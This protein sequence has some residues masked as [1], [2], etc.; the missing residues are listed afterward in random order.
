MAKKAQ[1]G[2]VSKK[3]SMYDSIK[4][5]A[6]NRLIAYGYHG[7]TFGAIAESLHITT[8]NI[9][10]HFGSK[11][12]L[13]E[14][15]VKDYVTN[16]SFQHRAIWLDESTSLAEKVQNVVK[17]NY[18]LYKKFNR[19]KQAKNPWSLIGRMRLESDVLSDETNASLTSF[20]QSINE[21]IVQAVERA[22]EKGQLRA[23]TPLA[24]LAF[25]LTNLVDSSSVFAQDAGN[26]ER[27]EQFFNAF[28]RVVLSV[29]A[30]EP[31]DESVGKACSAP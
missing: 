1:V 15:V 5:V 28:S 20:T 21:A 18:K 6:R 31:A 2:A 22:K 16:A 8:T 26:F 3:T 27:L 10:Y 14:E 23:D 24:D 13:V 17:Y 19:G 9:H 30:I 7:T 12:K 25:L 11:S 29:Y 4:E